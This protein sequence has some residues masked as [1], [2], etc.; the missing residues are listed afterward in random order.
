MNAA[1]NI[2]SLSWTTKYSS[3]AGIDELGILRARDPDERPGQHVVD[4]LGEEEADDEAMRERDQRLDQPRA[5][6]DQVLHQR[7]LGRLDLLLVVFAAHAGLL[8]CL[9]PA[10]G[11]D[12]WPVSRGRRRRHA[13]RTAGAG[14]GRGLGA[15]EPRSMRLGRPP[16]RRW[17]APGPDIAAGFRD[18]ALDLLLRAFEFLADLAHGIEIRVALRWS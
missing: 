5:Q 1:P 13:V 17:L 18:R 2:A 11:S 15:R 7:R 9:L 12:A 6:L 16:R 8:S 14:S 10:P 4:R 3:S